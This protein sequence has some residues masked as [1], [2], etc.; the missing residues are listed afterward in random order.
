MS[1]KLRTVD[2]RSMA[3]AIRREAE[4]ARV[5]EI[6]KR[7][8]DRRARHNLRRRAIKKRQLMDAFQRR[9]AQNFLKE[10]EVTGCTRAAPPLPPPP[11]PSRRGRTHRHRYADAPRDGYIWSDLRRTPKARLA[12]VVPPVAVEREK[13]FI[14]RLVRK[15]KEEDMEARERARMQDERVVAQ[16]QSMRVKVALNKVQRSLSMGALSKRPGTGNKQRVKEIVQT[17]EHVQYIGAE[18]HGPVP[19]TEEEGGGNTRRRNLRRSVL[20]QRHEELARPRKSHG[21]FRSFVKS[22]S[23]DLVGLLHSNPALKEILKWRFEDQ[24]IC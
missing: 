1:M 23:T 22:G 8:E 4:H 18:V 20:S 12:M 21:I 2:V 9:R 15:V 11:P 7:E 13:E 3:A 10:D 6:R 19:F 17:K 16:R 14:E 5:V 24:P